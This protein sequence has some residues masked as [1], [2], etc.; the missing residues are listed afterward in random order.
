MIWYDLLQVLL[1]LSGFILL[2]FGVDW[3][4]DWMDTKC[5]IAIRINNML[6]VSLI[7]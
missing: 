6:D 1:G 5:E 4:G 2:W 7:F 3:F